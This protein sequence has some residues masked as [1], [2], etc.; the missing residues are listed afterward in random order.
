MLWKWGNHEVMGWSRHDGTKLKVM[1]LRRLKTK[2]VHDIS[3]GNISSIPVFFCELACRLS[4]MDILS[5][6]SLLQTPY[7]VCFVYL[8]DPVSGNLR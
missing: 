8:L 7:G 1:R 2:Y 4:F 6:L 5:V 3:F